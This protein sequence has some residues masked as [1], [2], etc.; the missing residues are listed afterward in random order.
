MKVLESGDYQLEDG[1]IIPKDKI[2]KQH[3][4][5]PSVKTEK[6]QKDEKAELQEGQCSGK[7]PLTD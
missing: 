2:A 1:T 5:A 4:S 3:L 7:I 6:K